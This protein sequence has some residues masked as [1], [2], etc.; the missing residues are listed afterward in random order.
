MTYRTG[1]GTGNYGV[2]AFGLD[3]AITEGISTVI[4]SSST[5]SSAEVIQLASA[6]LTAQASA[7]SASEKIFQSSATSSPSASLTSAGEKIFQGEA[8]VTAEVTEASASIQFI[9][10]AEAETIQG[11]ATF[12]SVGVRVPEGSASVSAESG[13]DAV[14]FI[15]AKG[16]SL[17]EGQA[18][19]ADLDGVGYRVRLGTASAIQG[20]STFASVD[21]REKWE[22]ISIES[23]SWSTIPETS[24]TWSNVA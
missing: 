11:S 15:T 18:T 12:T 23:Q 17:V 22:P 13:F 19:T 10:N 2:R 8:T 16:E 9:T 14:A 1:F 24:I 3:G 4:T 20:V 5:V 6:S 21:G 7:T